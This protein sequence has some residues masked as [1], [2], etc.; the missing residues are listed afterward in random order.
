[1]LHGGNAN[2][3]W[4]ERRNA[5]CRHSLHFSLQHFCGRV[6]GGVTDDK[7]ALVPGRVIPHIFLQQLLYVL[8]LA[9]PQIIFLRTTRTDDETEALVLELSTLHL[10]LFTC[11][12]LWS[13]CSSADFNR[14]AAYT[15]RGTDDLG[16]RAVL[17][18]MR[19]NVCFRV[20]SSRRL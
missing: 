2:V 3:M 11:R 6:S 17:F 9:I 7:M 5:T 12:V 4:A 8:Q 18:Q 20:I 15:I 16:F 13:Y 14:I 19:E 10:H 1:M